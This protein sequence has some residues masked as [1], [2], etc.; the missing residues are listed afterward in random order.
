MKIYAS[1]T[2]HGL[3]ATSIK[4]VLDI[5]KGLE[6]DGI[7][8]GSTHLFD[9]DFKKHVLASEF[10][11]FLVHNYCPPSSKNLVLNIA[12]VDKNIREESINHIKKCIKFSSDI[13][14]KLYTFHPGFLN[15]P[16]QSKISDKNY[17]FEFDKNT[18]SKEEATAHMYES[19]AKIQ[20][21]AKNLN[22][23][24]AIETEGSFRKHQVLLMQT[25]SEY[26]TFFKKT[27]GNIGINLNLAHSSLAAKVFNFQMP[28]FIKLLEPHL[29]AV[30]IS[31]CDMID[32]QHKPLCEGSYIFDLLPILPQ[33]IPF[34]LE[35]RN[36]KIQDLKD[37]V[38]LIK[39]A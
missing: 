13:N 33:N 11:N 7:E 32:D 17:D 18:A 36:A 5:M 8:L 30:E 37:S 23:N 39:N 10:N 20:D 26:E 29:K 21:E 34:I 25:P 6:I 31:H 27:Q 35:F 15:T 16:I 24:I 22:V 28:S 4:D 3:E 12:S 2:F 14:A 9:P 1:T 38:N 19:L